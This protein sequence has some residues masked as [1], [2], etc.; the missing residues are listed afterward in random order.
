M[1]SP[2]ETPRLALAVQSAAEA[3]DT[4]SNQVRDLLKSGALQ[5]FTIA[6]GGRKLRIPITSIEAFIDRRVAAEHGDDPGVI[7]WR[8]K[9]HTRNSA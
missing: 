8:A 1:T 2:A 6:D 5:G 3:L 4:T 7:D 9:A